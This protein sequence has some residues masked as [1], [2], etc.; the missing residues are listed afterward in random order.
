MH[1]QSDIEGC[2]KNGATLD[3]I[4]ETLKIAVIGWGSITFQTR[5]LPC[6]L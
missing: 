1:L 5:G 3:E 6:L 4:T 2:E